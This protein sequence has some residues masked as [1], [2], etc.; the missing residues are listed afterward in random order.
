MV[1]RRTFFNLLPSTPETKLSFVA[2]TAKPRLI[3]VSIK[4]RGEVPTLKRPHQATVPYGWQLWQSF[5][6]FGYPETA[7]AGRS[8]QKLF[9]PL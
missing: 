5:D 4:P 6:V 1:S 3:S 7:K 8:S 9:I 2:P